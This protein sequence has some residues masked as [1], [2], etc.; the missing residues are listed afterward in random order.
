MDVRVERTRRSLQQALL[1]LAQEH[2]P[3]D[4]T[5]AGIVERAGVNRSSFYQHY[6]D[7]ETLLA[8]AL[9]M[10]ESEAGAMVPVFDG[11]LPE[12]PPADLVA[13]LQHFE[14]N[15]ALYRLVLCEGGSSVA[16]G[17]IRARLES[18]ASAGV[19]ASGSRAFD[20]LPPDVVGAGIAGSALGVIAVWLDREPRPPVETAAD[21]VWR[22]LIGPGLPGVREVPPQTERAKSA[23]AQQS[24]TDGK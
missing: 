3:G 11:P 10:V 16:A 9:D 19:A 7:K 17:R 4:I 12:H 14:T 21:W 8:D 2:P 1:A 20:G 24:G 5:I 13:Y 18:A 23:R 6:S 15:A 22:V